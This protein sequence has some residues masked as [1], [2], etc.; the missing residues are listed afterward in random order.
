MLRHA[1]SV[2][3]RRA[4]PASLPI[5]EAQLRLVEEEL[6]SDVRARK[7]GA[8]LATDNDSRRAG[9]TPLASRAR[10]RGPAAADRQR[11]ARL[12]LP[13][14]PRHRR[15]GRRAARPR[16]QGTVRPPLGRSANRQ[17]AA[18]V[19]ARRR[20]EQGVAPDCIDWAAFTAI[21]GDHSC[22]SSSML[23]SALDDR[24]D[25]PGRRRGGAAEGR[26]LA[27]RRRGAAAT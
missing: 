19:R 13:R 24:L 22:S 25:P 15:A 18:P 12:G 9:S 1:L 8:A 3:I 26:P 27:D 21:A 14:A 5:R 7:E 17:R 23:D 11:G 2:A 10:V 16:A 4:A 6:A 20:L